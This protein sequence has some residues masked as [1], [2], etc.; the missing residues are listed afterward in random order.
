MKFDEVMEFDDKLYQKNIA[1]HTFPE[2]D[3]LDGKGETND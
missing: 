3:D 2:T 1:D